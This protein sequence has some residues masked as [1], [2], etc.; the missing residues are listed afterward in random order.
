M[1]KETDT[2]S[3][4]SIDEKNMDDNTASEEIEFPQNSSV[5]IHHTCEENGINL[6]NAE[7][8]VDAT[9]IKSMNGT[10]DICMNYNENFIHKYYASCLPSNNTE[11]V[12]SGSEYDP[13]K[14]R[15][16]HDK[17]LS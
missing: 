17:I 3:S 12:S 4:T 14:R 9:S 1:H 16:R 15:V 11:D 13:A 8:E 6:L 10:N 2:E 7:E 5:L